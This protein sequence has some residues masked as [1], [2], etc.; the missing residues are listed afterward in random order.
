E[1]AASKGPKQDRDGTIPVGK[2]RRGPR[3][4]LVPL[5]STDPPTW[6][7]ILGEAPLELKSGRVQILRVNCDAPDFYYSDDQEQSRIHLYVSAPVVMTGSTPLRGGRI[8]YWVSV[9][10]TLPIGS[11]GI[12]RAELR[13]PSSPG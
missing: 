3:R 11:K 4:P 9:P 12:A 13:P 5:P 10:E 7:D 1:P 6:I 8:R 2:G